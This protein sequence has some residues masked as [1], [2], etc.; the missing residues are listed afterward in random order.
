M[1]ASKGL[2][3][4]G[5]FRDWAVIDAWARVIARELRTPVGVG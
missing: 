2:L 4:A 3:P 5:D 1:P